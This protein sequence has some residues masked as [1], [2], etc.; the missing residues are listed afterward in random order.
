MKKA[1]QKIDSATITALA[2]KDYE[3][4]TKGEKSYKLLNWFKDELIL[5][6]I[7]KKNILVIEPRALAKVINLLGLIRERYLTK[8][9]ITILDSSEAQISFEFDLTT[10]NNAER[11]RLNSEYNLNL[12]ELTT[13]EIDE[14]YAHMI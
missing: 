4:Y 6:Q 2:Q 9:D 14:T 11:R 7:H 13:D 8:C 3:C 5:C 1:T 12:E 10:L